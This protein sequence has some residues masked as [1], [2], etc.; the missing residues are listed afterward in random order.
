MKGRRGLRA[1]DRLSVDRMVKLPDYLAT[2]NAV[3]IPN[4]PSGPSA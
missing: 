1:S 4:I 2:M 3:T